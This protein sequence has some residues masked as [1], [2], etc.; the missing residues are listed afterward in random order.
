MPLRLICPEVGHVAWQEYEDRPLSE[1]EVRIR[2]EFGVEK[3]GTMMAFYKGYGNAR[4]RWD[5][6]ALLHRPEGVL[7]NYP[8]PLGNMQAGI[9]TEAGPGVSMFREGDRVFHHGGFR[10]TVEMRATDCWPLREGVNWRA[11]LLLDPAEFALGAMRD[12]NVRVGDRV[13]IFGMGAIGLVAIQMAKIAGAERIYGVDPLP[14]RREAALA[15]GANEAIDPAGTDVGLL[16]RGKTGGVGIDVAI[17]FSGS[18]PALQA[19]IRGVGY[20][21]TIVC[22]AFPPPYDAGLDFGGEAHM[23]RPTIV[24]SRACSDPNPE[25]PRWS[26]RRIQEACVDLIERGALDG[27]PI[28]GETIPFEDLFTEYPKIA[29]HATSTIKLAVHY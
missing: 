6:A 26:H 15:C 7:W 10:P 16:L 3:H 28:I 20:H 17:D 2:H 1:G 11:A 27:A 14:E 29:D 12:G 24:F 8:I 18:R 9:V 4:G 21:A 25:Y 23:N 13:A 22:G 5:A 19:A